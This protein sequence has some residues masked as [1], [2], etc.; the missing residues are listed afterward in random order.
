M[1]TSRI[2]Y[3]NHRERKNGSAVL[4]Y[5]KTQYKDSKGMAWIKVRKRG[6]DF[7]FETMKGDGVDKDVIRFLNFS[8]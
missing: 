8:M 2:G 1:N 3:S 7:E 6:V 5:M 4:I